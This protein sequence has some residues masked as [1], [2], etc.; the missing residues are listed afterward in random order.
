ML[1]SFD[2]IS[3]T[4]TEGDDGFVELTLVKSGDLSRATVVTVTTAD[5]SATGIVKNMCRSSDYVL[6]FL[7]S[8][9]FDY[10]TTSV[11]VTFRPDSATALARVPITDDNEIENEEAFTAVLSSSDSLGED[12]A[13]VMILDDDG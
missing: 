3:Y 12:I 6:S 11:E 4:V 1:V 5:G 9:G 10:T 13:T 2:P 8:A 7:C